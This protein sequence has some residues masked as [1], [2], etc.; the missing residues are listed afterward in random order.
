LSVHQSH[1]DIIKAAQET[2]SEAV[3]LDAARAELA[4]LLVLLRE[5]HNEPVGT[6]HQGDR[7]LDELRLLAADNAELTKATTSLIEAYDGHLH[8][9]D[10]PEDGC[11]EVWHEI[12]CRLRTLV[13]QPHP[14]QAILDELKKLKEIVGKL[15][16]TKDGVPVVPMVDSAWICDPQT[17][18][19][20]EARYWDYDRDHWGVQEKFDHRVGFWN[21]SECY[22]THEAAERGKR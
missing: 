18:C 6:V 16:K 22:S 3:A 7:I 14:G 5:V 8:D 1:A 21:V 19:I 4:A 20:A 9:C 2:A 10:D 13:A 12:V 11:A 17:G 15:P